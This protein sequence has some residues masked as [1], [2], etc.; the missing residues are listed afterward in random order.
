MD[1]DRDG[2]KMK[3]QMNPEMNTKM[4]EWM[5]GQI[6]TYMDRWKIYGL[7]DGRTM[8]GEIDICM[9]EYIDGEM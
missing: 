7:I 5:Y 2:W 4:D 3:I 1:G 9:N 8:D 6:Y